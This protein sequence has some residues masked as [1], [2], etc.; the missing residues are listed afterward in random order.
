MLPHHYGNDDI[1]RLFPQATTN[2][3]DDDAVN[4]YG[5][6]GTKG[7]RG[8][9]VQVVTSCAVDCRDNPQLEAGRPP[10]GQVVR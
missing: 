9:H 4:D 8:P 7:A 10:D 2:D 1:A 3:D 6:D 5:P